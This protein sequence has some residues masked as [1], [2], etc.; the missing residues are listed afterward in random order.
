MLLLSYI[1]KVRSKVTEL[2]LYVIN[3]KIYIEVSD[4]FYY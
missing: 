1:D 3:L 2:L 4:K